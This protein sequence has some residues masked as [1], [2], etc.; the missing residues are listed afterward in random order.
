MDGAI[1]K[2]YKKVG[3]I[4]LKLYLFNPQKHRKGDSRPAV[5]FFFGGGWNGGNP[6]QFQRHCE[7]LRSRGIVAITADYRVRGRHNTLV[8]NCVMDARSAIRWVREHSKELGVDPERIASGGGSAGGHLG[9]CVGTLNE[10]DGLVE[11]TDNKKISS[12]PNAMILF[13]PALVLA[14]VKG[15]EQMDESKL[16]KR[17]GVETI[18]LSPFHHIHKKTPPAVIFHGKDDATVKYFTAELFKN[19]M[20]KMGLDCTL[21]GYDSMGHGFFNYGKGDGESFYQTLKQMD[22]FL[23]RLKWLKGKDGVKAFRKKLGD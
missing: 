15:Q 2:T 23:I 8:T 6:A 21:H 12:L 10:S 11:V 3:G 5:V 22:D 13:N 19:K 14:N 16:K 18:T 9:A 20:K 4:P 1:E 17:M 7:Y